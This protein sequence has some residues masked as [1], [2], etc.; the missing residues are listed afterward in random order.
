MRRDFGVYARVFRHRALVN[1]LV[2]GSS[3]STASQRGLPW[4]WP[5]LIPVIQTS[6]YLFL[7]AGLFG[8]RS[9][10][11][12]AMI[13]F[14]MLTWSLMTSAVGAASGSIVAAAPVLTQLKVEPSNFV[15]AAIVQS[16][17]GL[18]YAVLASVVVPVL[19]LRQAPPRLVFYPLVLFGWVTLIWGVAFIVGVITVF[20][21]DIEVGFPY[22]LTIAMLTS[23]VLYSID[24]FPP[25]LQEIQSWNPIATIFG[26][27]R[28]SVV[29]GSFVTLSSLGVTLAVIVGQLVLGARLYRRL[30]P[31]MTKVL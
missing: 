22:L 4:L 8:R 23:P 7:F 9:P 18:R 24:I 5:V 14:G 31:M 1:E 17:W 30:A 6:I 2:R 28:W 26:L 27:F 19:L 25:L 16:L 3:M 29:G 12:I 13:V 11:S 10:E 20:V 21:R 15:A